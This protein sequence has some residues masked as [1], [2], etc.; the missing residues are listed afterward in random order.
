MAKTQ[1]LTAAL[2]QGDPVAIE[3]ALASDVVFRTPILSEPLQG[4]EMTL[5]FF[6]QAEQIVNGLTYYDSVADGEQTLMFWRGDVRDRPIEGTT[7]ISVDE[8][9]L[10]SELTVLM[11][12]WSVVGLFRDAMLVALA[13]VFPLRWWGLQSDHAP[14]PDPDGGVGRPELRRLAPDVR[15]HSPM[16]T[17]TVSGADNVHA[18]HDLIAAVQGPRLYRWRV[19]SDARIV[20]LWSC[21]I[22]GHAQYG[23]DLLD[24]DDQGRVTDQ[25]VWLAPWP[26]TTLL[27]DRAIAAQ[28]PI[29]GPEL[30]LA[31]SHPVPLA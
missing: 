13:D 25:R 21:V 14:T 12:S 31:P 7:L 27:R 4:R 15:F 22:E 17:A 19:S 6:G 9:G 16:L 5:R 29:L 20:E 30:W 24:L 28:L 23:I 3:A 11:R 18:V 26:V 1:M 2:E 8:R 10:V